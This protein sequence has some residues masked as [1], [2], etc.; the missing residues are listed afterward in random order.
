MHANGVVHTDGNSEM[1]NQLLNRY[2]NAPA[3]D[4]SIHSGELQPQRP[5]S[6]IPGG[7]LEDLLFYVEYQDTKK[8]KAFDKFTRTTEESKRRTQQS[9]KLPEEDDLKIDQE[10]MGDME[11]S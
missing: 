4:N 6:L 3:P 7:H 10:K 2:S 1:L 9:R 11:N 8:P 5:H